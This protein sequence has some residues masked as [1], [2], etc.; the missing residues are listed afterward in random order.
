MRTDEAGWKSKTPA[1][2]FWNFRFA[3]EW[4]RNQEPRIAKTA[5][6]Q[7]KPEKK[8]WH[9]AGFEPATSK[10]GAGG[11]THQSTPHFCKK[12]KKKKKKKKNH[13]EKA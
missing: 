12:V 11:F 13:H 1:W 5:K 4:P 6:N 7:K 9:W 8:F 2:N 3:A 10:A